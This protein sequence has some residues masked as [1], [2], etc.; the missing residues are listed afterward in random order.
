MRCLLTGVSLMFSVSLF[1]QALL[2]NQKDSLTAP[3]QE[4]LEMELRAF[5]VSQNAQATLVGRYNFSLNIDRWHLRLQPTW[6]FGN[7]AP[8]LFNAFDRGQ[9]TPPN[10]IA[11]TSGVG[12]GG[13]V[14]LRYDISPAA[15]VD[16][17]MASFADRQGQNGL[18]LNGTTAPAPYFRFG[19]MGEHLSFTYLYQIL[20]NNANLYPDDRFFSKNKG[21][22]FHRV[23]YRR[24]HWSV[25]FFESVFW[26][27]QDSLVTRYLDPGY[28]M[29]FAFLRPVEFS[30]GSSD[31]VLLGM[32]LA[33]YDTRWKGYGQLVLDEF[34]LDEFR[35]G[36]GWWANKWAWQLGIAYTSTWQ[37]A[38]VSFRLEHNRSR[39]FTFSH[40]FPAQ[41]VSQQGFALGHPLGSN[42]WQQFLQASWEKEPWSISVDLSLVNLG[43]RSSALGGDILA[44]NTDRTADFGFFGLSQPDRYAYAQIE[45]ARQVFLKEQTLFAGVYA[46]GRSQ[47][48]NANPLW[49][50]VF[51]RKGL[52]RNRFT[53]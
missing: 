44:S 18:L 12:L 34:K 36:E 5:G 49:V 1:A 29:P 19:W 4:P 43:S 45:I 10:Y 37:D 7:A 2:I 30:S 14:T 42:F 25:G 38:A 40:S 11:L 33:V 9:K 28:L 51:V 15:W 32:D 53:Y 35:S 31:N 26:S 16:A 41:S 24:S 22:V 48:S 6:F 23:E 27:V 47:L 50:G 39:P 21:L 8:V 20:Q 3:V 52:F 17:G 46:G 13:L